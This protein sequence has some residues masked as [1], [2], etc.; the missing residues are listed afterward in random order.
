MV[1]HKKRVTIIA[2]P[3]VTLKSHE[4]LQQS[5]FSVLFFTNSV[6]IIPKNVT[7]DNLQ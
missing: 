1:R 6:T 7:Y 2:T 3:F 4:F 5:I